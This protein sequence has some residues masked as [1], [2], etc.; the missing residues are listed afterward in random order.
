MFSFTKQSMCGLGL[1]PSTQV[2]EVFALER[3]GA[4]YSF[5]TFQLVK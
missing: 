3:E 1:A 2:T 5:K 4:E